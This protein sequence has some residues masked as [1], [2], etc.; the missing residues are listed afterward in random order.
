[1]AG[2]SLAGL[3]RPLIDLASTWPAG[4]SAAVVA[5]H[6]LVVA[7]GTALHWL[8]IRPQGPPRQLF[9]RA[10]GPQAHSAHQ[11]VPWRFSALPPELHRYLVVAV[12][13]MLSNSS[14][15]FLLLRGRQ[16][17]VPETAIPLLRAAISALAMFGAAPLSAWFDRV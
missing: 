5:G 9:I 15:L 10:H 13:V 8:G 4:P 11:T 2:Y 1:M 3:S 17:G 7:A 14:N 16:L 6:R 12:L